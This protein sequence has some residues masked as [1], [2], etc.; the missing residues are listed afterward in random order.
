MSGEF[1]ID[2]NVLVYM[3]DK[4]EHDK[5]NTAQ[6]LVQHAL[7]TNQGMISYQVAQEF[8]NVALRK[9][10]GPLL[11]HKSRDF[12]DRV[13]TPLCKV[14]P[15]MPLYQEALRIHQRWKFSFY[16]S[17]IIASAI[18]ANAELLYSEDM[19]HGQRIESITLINPFKNGNAIHEKIAEYA[20]VPAT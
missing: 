4:Q 5:R 15:S 3:F 14:Y 8:L 1:F 9:F 10:K 6:R 13:L 17:L 18:H 11:D 12:L 20:V 7:V 19:Q 2:T 16:D